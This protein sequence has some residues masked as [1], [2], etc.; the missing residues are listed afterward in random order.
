MHVHGKP[1]RF[2]LG[3][4]KPTPTL[5]LCTSTQHSIAQHLER[6][7]ERVF[8][9][10][11]VKVERGWQLVGGAVCDGELLLEG[12]AGSTQQRQFDLVVGADGVYSV[13]RRLMAE[14]VWPL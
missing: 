14:Q 12:P 4:G 1:E 8:G 6:E 2:V 7:C 9:A 11:R 5:R 3:W 10:E 13:T